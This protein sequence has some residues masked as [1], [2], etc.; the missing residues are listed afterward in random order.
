[1]GYIS[2]KPEMYAKLIYGMKQT[3]K[4]KNLGFTLIELLVVIAILGLMSTLVVVNFNQL[5]ASRSITLAENEMVSEIRKVQGYA[6]SGHDSTA[7]S[8]NSPRFF[9]LTFNQLSKSYTITSVEYNNG[10]YAWNDLETV[11]INEGAAISDVTASNLGGIKPVCVQIAYSV[12]YARTY[13]HASDDVCDDS[14]TTL[15]SDPLQLA[16]MANASA[17]VNITNSKANFVKSVTAYG[18]TGRVEGN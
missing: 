12:P 9:V 4:N 3:T 18:V 13:V 17:T 10:G 15:L 6:L 16:Q 5:R 7:N 14:I 2:R 11:Q 1:M 8:A